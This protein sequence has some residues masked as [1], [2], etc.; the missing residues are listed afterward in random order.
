MWKVYSGPRRDQGSIRFTL[1]DLNFV[2]KDSSFPQG[3]PRGRSTQPA[4]VGVRP[5][6]KTGFDA[7]EKMLVDEMMVTPSLAMRK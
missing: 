2:E 7:V 3:S 6:V 1:L 4:G 5:G